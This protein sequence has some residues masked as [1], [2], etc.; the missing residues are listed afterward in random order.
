MDQT[1]K[2]LDEGKN[3]DI[4]YLDFA[5]AFDK[6]C[7]R[8]LIKKLSRIGIAGILLEWIEN[9]LSGRKQRVVLEGELSEWADVLSSVLQGSVLGAILFNIF[10]NDVDTAVLYALLWK[11]ADDTKMAMV[12]EDEEDA[13]KMQEDLDNLNRWASEWEMCFNASKCKVMHVGNNNRKT[14]Y[15]MDG[16]KLEEVTK[17]YGCINR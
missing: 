3:F 6:V 12:V 16:H 9:W 5:K 2:W 15:F 8:R 11:F 4:I 10:I 7:H 13:R 14:D 1:T 17:E